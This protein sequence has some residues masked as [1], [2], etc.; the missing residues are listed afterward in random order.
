M[1]L[2]CRS[3]IMQSAKYCL[4]MWSSFFLNNYLN[5]FEVGNPSWICQAYRVEPGRIM[6]NRLRIPTDAKQKQNK[7]QKLNKLLA[8]KL[9]AVKMC[10]GWPTAKFPD[11]FFQLAVPIWTST[12]RCRR[13]GEPTSSVAAGNSNWDCD[14]HD[15]QQ[16][17]ARTHFIFVVL[18]NSSLRKQ[19]EKKQTN[20]NPPNPSVDGAASKWK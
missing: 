1:C 11:C 10:V 9:P 17:P 13:R 19:G 3:L 7:E 5:L 20:S 12:E 8:V 18:L 16:F 2:S 14:R 15:T 6:G 4:R